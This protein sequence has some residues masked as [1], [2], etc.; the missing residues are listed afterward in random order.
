MLRLI[1]VNNEATEKW[2]IL[3]NLIF[4]LNL[5]SRIYGDSSKKKSTFSSCDAFSGKPSLSCGKQEVGETPQDGSPKRL[6][7]R[8]KVREVYSKMRW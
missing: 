8:P 3:K 5:A 1:T 2:W 6:D 7:T 4:H